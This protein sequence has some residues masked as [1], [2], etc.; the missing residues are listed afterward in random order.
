MAGVVHQ[1]IDTAARGAAA[2]ATGVKRSIVG[3]ARQHVDVATTSIGV[4]MR[5]TE[6]LI[7]RLAKPK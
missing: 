6:G 5:E 3:A 2:L 7:N 1:N 4:L